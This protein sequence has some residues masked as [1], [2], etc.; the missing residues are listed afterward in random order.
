MHPGFSHLVEMKV[1]T[2]RLFLVLSV[3]RLIKIFGFQID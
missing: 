2:L 3:F 1:K